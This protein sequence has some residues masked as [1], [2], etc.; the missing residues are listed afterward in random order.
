MSRSTDLPLFR[1]GTRLMA[2]DL[3]LIVEA[4]R[5]ALRTTG[6]FSIADSSA[7]ADRNR[8]LA[9]LNVKWVRKTGHRLK[10]GKGTGGI[11]PEWEYS[12]IQPKPILQ[13]DGTVILSPDINLA[14][15]T[16]LRNG[17]P[18]GKFAVNGMEGTTGSGTTATYGTGVLLT[19]PSGAVLT[20]L[21]IPDGREF[22]L[23]VI[24]PGKPGGYRFAI[25]NGY[26]IACGSG[27]ATAAPPAGDPN[28]GGGVLGQLLRGVLRWP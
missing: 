18:Y 21:P 5:T 7:T 15:D 1:P 6:G 28:F 25:E 8:P 12:W 27:A 9:P 19:Q 13:G 11:P 10:A 20:P 3:N 17:D 14:L 22:P 24:S 26:S 4:V 16:S 2:A 23:V